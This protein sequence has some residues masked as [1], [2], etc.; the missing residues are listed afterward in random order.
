MS[1]LLFMLFLEAKTSRGE[2]MLRGLTT[3]SYWAEDVN[4]AKK[5]YSELLGIESYFNVPNQDGS[6]GY[7]EFRLGDYQHELGI[8]DRS[9]APITS[10]IIYWH[11]ANVEVSLERLVAMGAKTLE[12]PKD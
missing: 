6:L 7:S 10:T 8:I 2:T 4:V 9:Y 3:V 5:W 12:P 11:V 1:R